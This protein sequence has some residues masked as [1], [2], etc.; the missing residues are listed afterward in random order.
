[1]PRRSAAFESEKRKVR[2]RLAIAHD[3]AVRRRRARSTDDSVGAGLRVT[4]LGD[5]IPMVA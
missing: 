1:M 2:A 4:T 5:T 3:T